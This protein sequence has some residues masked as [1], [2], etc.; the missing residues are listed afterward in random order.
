M[1]RNRALALLPLGALLSGL[2]LTGSALARGPDLGTDVTGDPSVRSQLT[3]TAERLA[4]EGIAADASSLKAIRFDDGTLV[5][6]PKSITITDN[7]AAGGGYEVVVTEE[8][9]GGPKLASLE[10]AI[11]TAVG[12]WVENGDN[13]WSTVRGVTEMFTCYQ[14]WRKINDGSTTYDYR[15]I[16]MWAT[17]FSGDTKTLDWAWIT[18]DRDAGPALTFGAF[19]PVADDYTSSCISTSMGLS[20]PYAGVSFGSQWCEEWDITKS[21]GTTLGYF[22]NR[23]DWGSR[24]PI[25]GKDRYLAIKLG[26]RLANGGGGTTWGLSW[27]YTYH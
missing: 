10:G 2:L 20:G 19:E 22:K 5:V 3:K 26:V 11:T 18:V 25:Q 9:S 13:C 6:S 8:E 24:S 15:M 27:D 17:V 23:W 7:R 21:Q 12:S 1:R 14:G 16:D 4:R